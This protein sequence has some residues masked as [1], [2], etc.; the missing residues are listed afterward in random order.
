MV[1]VG[2][3]QNLLYKYNVGKAQTNDKS[4]C[5][6]EVAG[7]LYRMAVQDNKGVNITTSDYQSFNED[8]EKYTI[9][10][11]GLDDE[12]AKLFNQYMKENKKAEAL[13]IL[14]EN[15]NLTEQE[16]SNIVSNVFKGL[17][18]ASKNFIE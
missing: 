1:A 14:K 18:V 6:G 15:S 2:N 10:A 9:A 8:L 5:N 16:F 17:A 7:L 12:N 3:A 4:Q 11:L 13:K